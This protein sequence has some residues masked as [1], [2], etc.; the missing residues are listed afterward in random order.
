LRKLTEI[1]AA[2]RDRE[3]AN[4]ETMPSS[5]NVKSSEAGWLAFAQDKPK[6]AVV[7]L[8]A[9]AQTEDSTHAEPFAAPAREM[10]ADLLL[11]LKRPSEALVEYKTVLCDYPNRFD[12]LLGAAHA[13]D[14]MNDH[15]GASGYFA[16]LV[17]NCS[18]AAD[19]P[20]LRE[21]SRYLA[22]N[23]K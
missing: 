11:A 16:K 15:R 10:L 12:S 17:A 9:A 13:E 18:A 14:A 22:A 1:V 20:E 2:R 8:R 21:A 7:K 4:G 3:R 23:A 19:R 6:E 5:D